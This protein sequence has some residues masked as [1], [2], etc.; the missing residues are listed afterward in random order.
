[1]KGQLTNRD[2]S[3][4]KTR[5]EHE[6]R[7]WLKSATTSQNG[8]TVVRCITGSSGSSNWIV[9]IRL[10]SISMYLRDIV[11]ARPRKLEE[12]EEV[13]D[14]T[15]TNRPDLPSSFSPSRGFARERLNELT[16][17]NHDDLRSTRPL[18]IVNNLSSWY[19]ETL[20][21]REYSRIFLF[22]ME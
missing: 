20:G 3:R 10:T 22:W 2:R 5:P 7:G 4:V 13:R 9:T 1:M 12:V 18:H 16:S 17:R 8:P 11:V 15:E 21:Y 14:R 6:T 19:N